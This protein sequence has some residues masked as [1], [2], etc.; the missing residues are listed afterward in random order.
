MAVIKFSRKEFEKYVK[1]NKEIEEK[2][3]LLGTPVNSITN[4]EIEIEVLPNRPDLF[5][6]QGFMNAFLAFLGKK[7][8]LKEYKINKPEK[9]YEVRIDK[10][11]RDVRP[12]TACAIIKNLKFDDEKIKEVIDIQ[13]KIHSTLGR[14]RKKIAIGIYP[15]EKITLPIKFEARKPKDIK[16]IPLESDREMNGLQILQQ[17]PAGRDYAYLLEGKDKYPVFVDAAGEILSMPPIINSGKTGKITE[18]TTDIFIECSGFDFSILKKALNILVAMLADMQGEIYQM[19]LKYDKPTIT[20]DLSSEKMKI[21]V[22]NTNKLLGLNLN[23]GDIKKFLERMGYD[24][25]D[26][27]V[28]VPAWRTD[29]MH[30]VDLIEDIAIAYGYDNFTPEIPPISTI[31]EIDKKEILKKKIAEILT[32]SGLLE[33]STY[34][35]LTKEDIGTL[36]IKS[37][38]VEKSKSDFKVLRPNLLIPALKILSENVDTEYP[39]SIFELG[40]VF[41]ENKNEE[42]GIQEQENL[43]AALTPANFTNAKQ[44]LDYL[45]RMLNIELKIKETREEHFIDGRAGQILLDNKE[46]GIIGE[47]HPSILTEWHLKMPLACFELRLEEIFK[48]IS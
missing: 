13:E 22:E 32:G 26:K 7:T 31:G 39:Q 2:I 15:L 20:P 43:V 29:I 37:V 42:T 10:S 17:H 28:S 24:Y 6:L 3:N 4:G 35:L 12:Y 19:N 45:A 36:K 34:H 18:K 11:V 25:K 44:A 33:I 9:N 40:T 16:F 30:E 1:L 23:E 47:I 5:S 48:K 27:Q 21:S 14:N 46:I 8:G 38:E 41:Q